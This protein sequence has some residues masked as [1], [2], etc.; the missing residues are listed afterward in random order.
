MAATHGDTF[1][2]RI[3]R[4]FDLANSIHGGQTVIAAGYTYALITDTP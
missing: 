4:S 2:A 1:E 3:R